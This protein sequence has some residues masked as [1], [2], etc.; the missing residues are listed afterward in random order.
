MRSLHALNESS[1]FDDSYEAITGAICDATDWPR[2]SV[3]ATL[4]TKLEHTGSPFVE[5]L[6]R[7][8][9]LRQ[10]TPDLFANPE[11]GP[12]LFSKLPPP[13]ILKP[14][15]VQANEQR[16]IVSPLLRAHYFSEVS[17]QLMCSGTLLPIYRFLPGKDPFRG[18]DPVETLFGV[19]RGVFE[20]LT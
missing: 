4:G 12:H 14:F 17:A 9:I 7:A 6:R 15:G 19:P 10:G 8:S 16:S 5:L 20:E 3:V 11:Y 2:P 18:D 1:P 13:F